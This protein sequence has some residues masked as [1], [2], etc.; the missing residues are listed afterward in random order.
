MFQK[1]IFLKSTQLKSHQQ[2]MFIVRL[3]LYNISGF[4]SWVLACAYTDSIL[5][6]HQDITMWQVASPSSIG[7]QMTALGVTKIGQGFS[8]GRGVRSHSDPI[9]PLHPFTKEVQYL[10]TDKFIFKQRRERERENRSL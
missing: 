5:F 7:A 10:R 6:H 8:D 1:Q 4:H 3:P 2:L 9:T